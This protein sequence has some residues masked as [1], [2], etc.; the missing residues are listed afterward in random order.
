M[1]IL[2]AAIEQSRH[3]AQASIRHAFRL[4]FATE[5]SL[6]RVD[7]DSCHGHEDIGLSPRR[8]QSGLAASIV[9]MMSNRL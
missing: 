5:M 1:T 8:H 9:D 4:R 6:V 2:V 7:F 3:V